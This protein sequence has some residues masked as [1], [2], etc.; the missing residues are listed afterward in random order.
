MRRALTLLATVAGLLIGLATPAQ[1]AI[2]GHYGHRNIYL[3]QQAQETNST[4]SDR[5]VRIGIE[6]REINGQSGAVDGIV[7]MEIIDNYHIKSLC[8]TNIALRGSGTDGLV[9][10]SDLNGIGACA[11]PSGTYVTTPDIQVNVGN[12]GLYTAAWVEMNVYNTVVYRIRVTS[13]DTPL[14]WEIA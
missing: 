2:T 7:V 8:T 1:A 6:V 9:P 10:G 14:R 3:N 5:A 11:P 13:Y 12:H 4:S